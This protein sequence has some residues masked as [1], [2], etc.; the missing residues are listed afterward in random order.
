MTEDDTFKKLKGLT[1]E[2]AEKMHSK[3]WRKFSKVSRNSGEVMKKIDVIFAPYG[4]KC[5]MLD[6][7]E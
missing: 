4:W 2:E 1:R 7:P 3:L 6:D 5:E